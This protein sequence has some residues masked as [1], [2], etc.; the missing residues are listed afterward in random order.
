MA[1]IDYQPKSWTD[2]PDEWECPVCYHIYE[3]GEP[4]AYCEAM[5]K[6]KGGDL[7]KLLYNIY[8]EGYEGERGASAVYQYV[9]DEHP[10]WPWELCR[11]CEDLTPSYEEVCAVCF[12]AR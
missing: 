12:V 2:P 10:D 9:N 3:V 4:C 8:D 6:A 1:S 7:T 11:D 5:N